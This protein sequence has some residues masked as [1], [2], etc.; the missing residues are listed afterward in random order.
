MIVWTYKVAFSEGVVNDALLVLGALVYPAKGA[1]PLAGAAEMDCSVDP[2]HRGV[3]TLCLETG[4]AS[5]SFESLAQRHQGETFVGKSWG[6]ELQK[7]QSFF[8][9]AAT[10]KGGQKKK[11][12]KRKKRRRLNEFSDWG[13]KCKSKCDVG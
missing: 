13:K 4:R 2:R 6:R 11:E 8:V 9:W 1:W 7:E 5:Q 10:I 12:K 3:R